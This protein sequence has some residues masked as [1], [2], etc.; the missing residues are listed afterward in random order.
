MK[1]LRIA[2]IILILIGVILL[3][4]VGVIQFRTQ[5]SVV[6]A[7]PIHVTREETHTIPLPPIVGGVA[8][9]AGIA[10]M[11]GSSRHP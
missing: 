6:D 1:R 10:L 2:G 11:L 8:L 4:Y 3:S 9:I 7:G 5:H